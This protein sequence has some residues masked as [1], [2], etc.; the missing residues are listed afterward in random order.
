MD[1]QIIG[2]M[3]AHRAQLT[4]ARSALPDAPV[5]DDRARARSVGPARAALARGLHRIADAVAPPK[6]GVSRL[7]LSTG[8]ERH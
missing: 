7:A 5:V 4:E 2:F 3:T 8:A 1:T 6:A